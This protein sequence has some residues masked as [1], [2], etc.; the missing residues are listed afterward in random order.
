MTGTG[1]V[2]TSSTT[3]DSHVQQDCTLSAGTDAV[4]TIS[5]AVDSHVQQDTTLSTGAAA[6]TVTTCL[7]A[8]GSRVPSIGFF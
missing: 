8:V 2:V 6:C 7:P 1:A 3:V 4:V 5:P